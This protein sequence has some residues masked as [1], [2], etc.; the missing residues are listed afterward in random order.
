[1]VNEQMEATSPELERL[2]LN[3]PS[4]EEQLLWMSATLA[5]M[6]NAVKVLAEQNASQ[7]MP[8]T[9]LEDHLEQGST[10]AATK[11]VTTMAHSE[12]EHVLLECGAMSA[13]VDNLKKIEKDQ[14]ALC[15]LL[16]GRFSFLRRFV[17]TST[18]RDEACMREVEQLLEVENEEAVDKT[19]VVTPCMDHAK[20]ARKQVDIQQMNVHEYGNVEY[21]A[22][23]DPRAV[24]QGEC[25]PRKD[26]LAESDAGCVA[27]TVHDA[28]WTESSKRERVTT[29][30]NPRQTARMANLKNKEVAKESATTVAQFGVL[31]NIATILLIQCQREKRTLTLHNSIK[32]GELETLA[33]F[34]SIGSEV[35]MRINERGECGRGFS[36]EAD[37]GRNP[38]IRAL[39]AGRT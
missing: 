9:V 14:T 6:A 26:E 2:L 4:V 30:R 10:R 32:G 13:E 12:R 35:D 38:V 18:E 20:A 16:S 33:K 22:F 3:E 11:M 15:E 34:H 27:T 7:N 28:E 29:L 8:A 5:E 31:Q 21:Y 39:Q 17:L 24:E 19:R 36:G 1:M 37:D 25:L 23:F